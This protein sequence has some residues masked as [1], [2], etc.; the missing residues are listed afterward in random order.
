MER[1]AVLRWGYNT[2]I[3]IGKASRD[4]P[5]CC[6]YAANRLRWFR[7]VRYGI[8]SLFSSLGYQAVAYN[9]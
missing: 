4:L 8:L 1:H 5:V 2:N 6:T 7:P 3:S 9:G